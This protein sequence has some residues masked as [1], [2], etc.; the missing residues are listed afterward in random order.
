VLLFKRVYHMLLRTSRRGVA[1]S[2][3]FRRATITEFKYD[4]FVEVSARGKSSGLG[5]DIGQK[6]GR[7]A[8]AGHCYYT[9]ETDSVRGA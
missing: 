4:S 1:S 9:N 2:G 8:C 6:Q 5:L 3:C 7:F